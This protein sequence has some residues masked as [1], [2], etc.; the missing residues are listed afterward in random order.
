MERKD[1]GARDGRRRK[2]DEFR[3][4]SFDAVKNLG[5]G[6][7]KLGFMEGRFGVLK[8]EMSLKI[9]EDILHGD[10]HGGCSPASINFGFQS[11]C[12]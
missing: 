4:V 3:G 2:E 5:Q 10:G 1:D 12:R 8:F 7:W 6:E 9:E 11:S